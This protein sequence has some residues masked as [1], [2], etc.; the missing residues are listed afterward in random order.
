MESLNPGD[1]IP[2]F[3]TEI[4]PKSYRKYNRLIGEINPIHFNKKYAQNIGFEGVV[5]AGNFL[6]TYI[7]KWIIDWIRK[8]DI[9]KN[10]S[11]KFDNPV[12]LNDQI[13]HEGTIAEVERQGNEWD[14]KIDYVVKKNSG[15]RT[16][17]GNIMLSQN[18]IR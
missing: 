5:V 13:I 11:I 7:P 4:N 10:I 14:I 17:Y 8:P 9:I 1:V 6:F 15:L 18:N 12:Y 16:S 2:A 3:R